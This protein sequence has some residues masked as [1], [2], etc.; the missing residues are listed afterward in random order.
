MEQSERQENMHDTIPGIKGI[1]DL[2]DDVNTIQDT[3]TEN[4]Y[5]ALILAEDYGQSVALPHYGFRCP[6]SDCF[7]SNLMAYLFVMADI[8]QG[9][10]KIMIYDER[11]MGKD[12][13]SLCSLRMKYHLES[14]TKCI[15]KGVNLPEVYI[16][17]QD[18][19]VGH[20]KSNVTMKF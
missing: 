16:S 18:N 6:S 1:D 11:C 17:I 15:D 14:R 13:N 2:L 8:S 10:N 7:N 5:T 9:E 20:N 3:S 12:K 19:C 4:E